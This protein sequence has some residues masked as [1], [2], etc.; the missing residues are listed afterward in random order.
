MAEHPHRR[1]IAAGLTALVIGFVIALAV[2]GGDDDTPAPET[3]ER[4]ATT[5]TATETETETVREPGET[6]DRPPPARDFAAIQATIV[7][8]VE[9]AETRNAQGV[10]RALGQT[11]AGGGQDAAQGCADRAGIDLA[12]L[13]S[14]DEL[15]FEQVAATG[16]RGRARLAS[17]DTVTLRRTGGRWVVTGISQ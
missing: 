16:N 3:T 2:A 11:P 9:S 17:G 7:L 8:L 5:E 6:V 4:P 15:S 12:A 10:C 13:P 1:A 14:S